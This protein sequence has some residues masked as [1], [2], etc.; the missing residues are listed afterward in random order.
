M[1]KLKASV[2]SSSTSNEADF[3]SVS[4][5]VLSVTFMKAV[6]VKCIFLLPL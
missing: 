6:S 2:I 5:K 1:R 4:L 3:S